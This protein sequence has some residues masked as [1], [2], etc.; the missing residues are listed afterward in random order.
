MMSFAAYIYTSLRFF[1][2]GSNLSDPTNPQLSNELQIDHPF[3]SDLSGPG[4]VWAYSDDMKYGY[5]SAG[6]RYGSST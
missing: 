5:I 6:E 1:T 3:P 2:S 4:N